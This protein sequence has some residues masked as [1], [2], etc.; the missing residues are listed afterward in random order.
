LVEDRG[1]D[2]SS[3]SVLSIKPP[4]LRVSDEPTS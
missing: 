4:T 2:Y 3:A 1:I